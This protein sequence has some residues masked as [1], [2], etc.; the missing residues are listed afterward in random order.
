MTYSLSVRNGLELNIGKEWTRCIDRFGNAFTKTCAA[1]YR[2]NIG[3]VVNENL[4]FWDWCIM[5]HAETGETCIEDIVDTLKNIFTKGTRV[6][7][8]KY[9]GKQKLPLGI[10]GTVRGVSRNAEILVALD[11]SWKI[12]LKYG[13]DVCEL[14]TVSEE[15]TLSEKTLIYECIVLHKYPAMCR[16]CGRMLEP[17]THFYSM[18]FNVEAEPRK[19]EVCSQCARYTRKHRLTYDRNGL[20]CLYS[21]KEKEISA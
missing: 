20:K 6:R 15:S 10:K 13:R 17:G 1:S 19:I 16:T 12:R 11:D 4:S 3:R 21:D 18:E 8:V 5:K 9:G 7:I 14:V 2:E